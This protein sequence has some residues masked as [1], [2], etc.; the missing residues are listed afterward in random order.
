MS[1]S[2]FDFLLSK[3][4]ENTDVVPYAPSEPFPYERLQ[5]GA[6]P[7]GSLLICFISLSCM[8]C[9]DLLPKLNDIAGRFDG[10]FVLAS[11]GQ[12]E[13]N[14]EIGEHFHFPFPLVTATEDDFSGVFRVQHTPYIYVIDAKSKVVTGG[15][16][17]DEKTFKELGI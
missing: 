3:V 8:R 10:Q 9:I 13:E 2:K 15:M 7:G 6:H 5:L 12:E 1:S 11:C 4:V 14:R 17:Q 16:I